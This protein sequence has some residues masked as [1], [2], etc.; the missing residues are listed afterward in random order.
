MSVV[1]SRISFQTLLEANGLE[2]KRTK[3][4]NLQLNV[5]K[6]CNLTCMHCHVNAGPGRKE[7]MTLDTLLKILAWFSS[8]DIQTV[9][10]TGG[11]P[12]M[13][14]GFRFLVERVRE[15]R[16]KA[17]IIDRC[18]LT[19][20]LE[21]EYEGL[22]AFLARHR[23]EIVASMPCY[24]PDN[25]EAQ[26]GNGV[27]DD[28]IQAL[29][30]LN[31]LGYGVDPDLPLNLVYN[32][33]GPSLPPDQAELETDYK[34]AL[35]DSFG[36]VFNNLY[37]ITNMPIARFLAYLKREDR[38]DEYMDLLVGSFNPSSVD[39]LMCRDTI[40]VDWRGRVFDCDFNQM[41]NMPFRGGKDIHLWELTPDAFEDESIQ[42]ASH[43][44]GC[45]AGAG[46]S[47]GGSLA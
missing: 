3:P 28:S 8:S 9:D 36:I 45:T 20:L 21:S 1:E 10:I 38:L 26:R 17:R 4:A 12:E 2:L 13:M 24:Q 37:T 32:P 19:I 30:L 41:L 46:S 43:C 11:A 23:V 16:P 15:I 42:L 33:L 44:F 35:Q 7:I 27:F 40:S 18:N 31:D 29:K 22:A 6:L 14:P 5:G 34:E 47:C 39:S 25:V